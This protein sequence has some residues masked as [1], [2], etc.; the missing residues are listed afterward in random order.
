[1]TPP[2]EAAAVP[3]DSPAPAAEASTDAA[4]PLIVVEDV[5]HSYGDREALRGVSFDVAASQVFGLLGPNGGGKTTLMRLLGTTLRLQ[6]GAMRVGGFD[7]ATQPDAVRRQL[8]ITFQ[9][10]SLDPKLTVWENVRCQGALYGL[11]GRALRDRGEELL[12]RLGVLD[13]RGDLC[14]TLS[15]GLKRRVEIA[16]SLLHCPPVLL[17]DEPSTGLDPGARHDLWEFLTG[18]ARRDGVTVF[19]S[20]HLMEEAERCHR[21]ALLSQ[22]ELIALGTPDELRSG[23]GGDCVT[24]TPT[25]E[26]SPEE[27]AGTIE[28]RFGLEPARID[29][30]LRIERTAGHELVRDLVAEVGDRVASVTLGKPTLEDVFLQKT[31]HRFWDEDAR[32]RAEEDARA[33]KKRKRA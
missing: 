10:P 5:A 33:P 32:G 25:P 15:G 12:A 17:L 16:K 19:V 28:S 20:T 13:R 22:G 3:S 31:G 18:L 6:S 2:T 24:I 1:M 27:L 7:V 4:A 11:G 8:G 30:Q 9:S 26:A 21:L 23:V 14:E 29:R